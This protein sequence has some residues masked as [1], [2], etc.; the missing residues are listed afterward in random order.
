MKQRVLSAHHLDVVHRSKSYEEYANHWR[1]GFLHSSL[2]ILIDIK[3]ILGVELPSHM[4]P[5]I[6]TGAPYLRSWLVC[7]VSGGLWAVR[8]AFGGWGLLGRSFLG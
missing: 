6:L 3:A 1:P 7:G 5:W 8:H 4:Y 2:D